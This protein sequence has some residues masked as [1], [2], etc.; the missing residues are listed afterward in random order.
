M[1]WTWHFLPG[2]LREFA[3]CEFVEDQKGPGRQFRSVRRGAWYFPAS[4]R[5]EWTAWAAVL[6]PAVR[7]MVAEWRGASGLAS[8]WISAEDSPHAAVSYARG[9]DQRQ[10][11]ALCIRLAGFGR[12]GRPPNLLVGAYRRITVWELDEQ[13][14]PWPT[15]E[16]GCRPAASTVW[17]FAVGSAAGRRSAASLLEA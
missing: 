11:H 12:S 16:K 10:P 1:G 7:R 6:E 3:L 17:A 2:L 5:L 9:A 15:H 14:V 4:D 13:D 8:D